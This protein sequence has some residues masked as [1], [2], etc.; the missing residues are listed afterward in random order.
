MELVRRAAFAWPGRCCAPI[1]RRAPRD[2][3][4]VEDMPVDTGIQD[5][6]AFSPDAQRPR[7]HV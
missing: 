2:I 1:L 5:L 3:C 7:S 6:W 4:Y